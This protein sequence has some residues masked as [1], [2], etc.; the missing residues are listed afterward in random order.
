MIYSLDEFEKFDKMKEAIR[1]LLDKY[2]NWENNSN[3]IYFKDQTI[4]LKELI[5]V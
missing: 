5:K 1:Y 3:L 4:E 2:P